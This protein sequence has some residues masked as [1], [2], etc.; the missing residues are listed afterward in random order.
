[1]TFIIIALA[2]A[3][4]TL[5]GLLALLALLPWLHARLEAPKAV[6]TDAQEWA[7]DLNLE[8]ESAP[9]THTVLSHTEPRPR[10][11]R[12]PR[13]TLALVLAATLACTACS[14]PTHTREYHA[15]E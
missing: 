10:A 11:T 8:L 5:F 2:P 7:E 3:A 9:L 6:Y 4:V 1:M 14:L 12:A 15:N 13:R